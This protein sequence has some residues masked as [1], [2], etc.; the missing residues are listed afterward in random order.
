MLTKKPIV[1]TEITLH[2]DI[3]KLSA[4]EAPEEIGQNDEWDEIDTKSKAGL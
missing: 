4:D 3:D 1:W 2:S